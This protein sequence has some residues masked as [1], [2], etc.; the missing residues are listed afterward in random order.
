MLLLFEVSGSSLAYDRG[1]ELELYAPFGV[2]EAWIID[3]DR[4]ETPM[5]R[6]IG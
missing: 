5:S 6:V 4:A 1:T 3:L 2:P